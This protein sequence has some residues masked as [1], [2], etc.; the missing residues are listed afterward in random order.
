[1]TL[2]PQKRTDLLLL[3]L[4]F[5]LQLSQPVVEVLDD[6]SEMVRL[7]G[8]VAVPLEETLRLLPL[9]VDLLLQL[10]NDLVPLQQG[11]RGDTAATAVLLL[12]VST[13]KL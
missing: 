4:L 1:M 9:A 8:Q 2:P 5:G 11:S 6:L 12:V 3:L 7:P 10:L 13:H